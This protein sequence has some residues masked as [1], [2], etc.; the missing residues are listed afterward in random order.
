MDHVHIYLASN[1]ANYILYTKFQY[2]NANID[3]TRKCLFCCY[4]EEKGIGI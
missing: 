2:A 3:N 4:E 1:I